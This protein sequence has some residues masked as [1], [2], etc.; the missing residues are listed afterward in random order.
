M[1]VLSLGGPRKPDK[2]DAGLHVPAARAF[3]YIAGEAAN[4]EKSNLIEPA[5]IAAE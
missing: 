2:A 1:A 5:A 4:N 3:H